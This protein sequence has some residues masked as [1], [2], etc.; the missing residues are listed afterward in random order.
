MLTPVSLDSCPMLIPDAR[1]TVI[2]L[3]FQIP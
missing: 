1:N 2:R 3:M